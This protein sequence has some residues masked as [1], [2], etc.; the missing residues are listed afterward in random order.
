MKPYFFGQEQRGSFQGSKGRI[1]SRV[2][3]TRKWC[4]LEKILSKITHEGFGFLL[5]L[6]AICSGVRSW[7]LMRAS[8]FSGGGS[9]FFFLSILPKIISVRWKYK[10]VRQDMGPSSLATTFGVA[11]SDLPSGKPAAPHRSDLSQIVQIVLSNSLRYGC[12]GDS[13]QSRQPAQ[14][15]SLLA[16]RLTKTSVGGIHRDRL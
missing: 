7:F 13:S 5:N 10:I 8:R 4:G 14:Q 3:I 16:G 12:S 15:K 6:L 1:T 9:F 11:R 2:F